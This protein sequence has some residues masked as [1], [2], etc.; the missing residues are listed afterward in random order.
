LLIILYLVIIKKKIFNFNLIKSFKKNKVS[1]EKCEQV[2]KDKIN[3]CF[4]VKLNEEIIG[5]YNFT[6]LIDP[7]LGFGPFK[8][9]TPKKRIWQ[10]GNTIL[11]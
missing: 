5:F 9:I 2:V 8:K 7:I 10:S 4:I 6:N 3:N 1:K 11:Y